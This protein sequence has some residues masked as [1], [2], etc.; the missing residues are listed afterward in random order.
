MPSPS[1]S[2]G[3][4][5]PRL[6]RSGRSATICVKSCQIA[7]SGLQT[8]PGFSRLILFPAIV[9]G[10]VDSFVVDHRPDDFHN[11]IRELFVEPARSSLLRLLPSTSF[12]I[13]NCA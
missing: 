4:R 8:A 3:V 5:L 7:S 13:P 1:S 2:R 12:P 6:V 10:S 11:G 9:I